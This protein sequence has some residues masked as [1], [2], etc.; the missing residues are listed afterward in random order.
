M[1]SLT[2]NIPDCII[3]GKFFG[4][5]EK[6]N[7][8]SYCFKGIPVFENEDFQNKL[9]E[10]VK[11]KLVEKKYNNLLK[12][13]SKLN[14]IEI[15]KHLNKSIVGKDLGITAEFA[16]EIISYTKRTSTY[17]HIICSLIID[18][19]NMRNYN[20]NSTEMC[21]YGHFGDPYEIEEIKSIPPP[22]PNRICVDKL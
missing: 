15:L 16:N 22:A 6:N 7:K 5:S 12:K 10:Y 21:Y 13:A 2:S 3:C 18:W 19:W 4:L 9:N 1:T 8:C 11:T 20:F 14:S 17:S